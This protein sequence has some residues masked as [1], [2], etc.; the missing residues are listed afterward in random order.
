MLTN[1]ELK[2]FRTIF[3]NDNFKV[4]NVEKNCNVPDTMV[5]SMYSKNFEAYISMTIDSCSYRK[6]YMVDKKGNRIEDVSYFI[7]EED[8]IYVLE[9]AKHCMDEF[10]RIERQKEEIKREKNIKHFLKKT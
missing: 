6:I 3:K 7:H 1:E 9:K 8:I 4:I 5:Y 2:K 10:F